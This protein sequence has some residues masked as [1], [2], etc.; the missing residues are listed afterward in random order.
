MI[1]HAIHFVLFVVVDSFLEGCAECC[2]ENKCTDDQE[3]KKS[4][5]DEK[6]FPPKTTT[7]MMVQ[8]I[9]I[10][11]YCSVELPHKLIYPYL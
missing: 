9:D 10:V 1:F 7:Q 3:E 5:H 8:N 4:K 11:E 2:R 6:R